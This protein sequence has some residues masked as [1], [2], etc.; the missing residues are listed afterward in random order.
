MC[1]PKGFAAPIDKSGADARVN[2]EDGSWIAFYKSKNTFEAH[3]PND[4]HV[5][6]VLSRSNTDWFTFA[7]GSK[8]GGRPLGFMMAWLSMSSVADK[9]DHW[10]DEC[11]QWSKDERETHRILL[12]TAPG[13]DELLQYEF[14][15]DTG[16]EP[17]SVEPYQHK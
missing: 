2:F 10:A 14:G 7:D 13:A 17:D 4:N 1:L 11:F 15:G 3:C 8:G 9:H 12:C 6:C 16:L 5:S